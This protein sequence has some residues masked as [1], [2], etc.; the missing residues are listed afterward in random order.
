MFLT[1][2]EEGVVWVAVNKVAAKQRQRFRGI[3]AA[4]DRARYGA[5]EMRWVRQMEVAGIVGLRCYQLAAG[6]IDSVLGAHVT[7]ERAF[8]EV[9]VA[10]GARHATSLPLLVG[11]CR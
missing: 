1:L 6:R 7:C 9:L 10:D 11:F 3:L 4:R 2:D 8:G 5:S